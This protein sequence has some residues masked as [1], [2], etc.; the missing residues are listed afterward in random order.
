MGEGAQVV[1]DYRA[2]GL[3]LRAH[4]LAFLRDELMARRMIT[5]AELQGI[6]DGRYV[7][8]AGIVLG[9]QK[10]GSAKGVMFLTIEDESDVANLVIWTRTFEANRRTVLG[11]SMMGVRGQVQREGDVIHVIARRL[12]DLSSMLASVGDR[13]DI[14]DVYRVSRADVVKH[15]MGPDPRD[16]AERPLGKGPR[17]IYIPDLRL[18]QG[19]DARLQVRW[20]TT[21]QPPIRFPAQRHRA[22]CAPMKVFWSWQ[23]DTHQPSNRYFVRDVLGELAKSLNG[24]DGAEEA[25]RPADGDEESREEDDV[26]SAADDGDV[27][28]DHDMK[29]FGGSGRIAD[30]IL[31]KIASAAVFVADV[32]PVAQAPG[33]KHVPNPNVM[34][35]LGYALH[36]LGEDRIVLVANKSF[37]AKLSRLPFDL[38]HRSA[39]TFYSLNQGTSEERKAEV[40]IELMEELRGRI[41]LALGEARKRMREDRRRTHRAAELSVI[42]EREHD[43]PLVIG[44]TPNRA[45]L[46]TL[47]EVKA[48]NPSLRMPRERPAIHGVIPSQPRL[49]ILSRGGRGRGPGQWTREETESF[50]RRL[51]HYYERYAAFLSE[52]DEHSKLALRTFQIQFAVEN[53]GTSPATGIDVE[54]RFPDFVRLRDHDEAP[55]TAPAPPEPP[56][57]VLYDDGMVRGIVMPATPRWGDLSDLKPY[58]RRS[59]T[60][61]A[62]ARLV[63][64][65]TTAL[66]HHHHTASLDP[67]TISFSAERDIASFDVTY[68]I[69]AN[70]PMDPF[71]GTVRLEILR[72]D[73]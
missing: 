50:N 46:K 70:E 71:E 38:R 8:L 7:E 11:A 61:D 65:S 4:P 53:S 24:L 68:F 27:L 36:V 22:T 48:E 55:P 1:E 63:H 29:G 14:A 44:Q 43:G 25:E 62:E 72:D 16:S 21:P 20:P 5:C 51:K 9:R 69:I 13:A 26:A 10:P 73:G 34:L 52:H 33:G 30:R 42:V 45:G 2:S 19:E 12:E 60:I 56:S 47:A 23:S 3:S 6:R 35:E 17:D 67:I 64:F 54:L 59:T 49:G 39:P 41:T 18:D 28:I 15:G 66:K 58:V 37:K 40:A 32:T 57:K 31:E